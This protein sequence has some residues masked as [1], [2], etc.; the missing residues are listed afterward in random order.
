MHYVVLE[1]QDKVSTIQ[2]NKTNKILDSSLK[3]THNLTPISSC[4]YSKKYIF[5]TVNFS[6]YI[7]QKI[8]FCRRDT[9][10]LN[11]IVNSDRTIQK[12]LCKFQVIIDLCFFQLS[13]KKCRESKQKLHSFANKFD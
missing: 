3:K 13:G 9:K 1:S 2:S 8:A 10:I 5:C 6:M 7:T 12:I 11:L 4:L